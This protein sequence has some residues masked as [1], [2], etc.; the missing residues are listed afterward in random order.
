M[1]G[2][3]M[4][5][6]T[7]YIDQLEVIGAGNIKNNNIA[8]T[9]EVY[10]SGLQYFD[11][12]GAFQEYT[13]LSFSVPKNAVLFIFIKGRVDGVVTLQDNWVELSNVAVPNNIGGDQYY[14]NPMMQIF[15]IGGGNHRIGV[16]MRMVSNG[17]GFTGRIYEMNMR[18]LAIIK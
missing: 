6:G 12:N 1:P 15:N 10:R 13:A 7:L 14:T 9:A 16:G 5:D 11:M 2:L 17:S 3:R 4:Q 18:I 8:V